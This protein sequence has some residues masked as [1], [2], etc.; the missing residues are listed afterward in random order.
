MAKASITFESVFRALSDTTRRQVLEQLS[1]GPASAS[2]LVKRFDMTLPSFVEHL[3]VLE[4]CGL[5][6]SK[7]SGRIRIFRIAPKR[8]KLAEDWLAGLRRNALASE[9]Q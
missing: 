8:L 1:K 4:R 5:V 9:K 3:A 2:Q 7:K 6:S